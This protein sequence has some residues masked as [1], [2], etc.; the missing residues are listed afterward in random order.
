ML[1]LGQ[2]VAGEPH[3]PFRNAALKALFGLATVK[4]VELQLGVGEA[5]ALLAT[6]TPH[7]VIYN[8][9]IC[10]YIA[11]RTGDG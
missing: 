4:D 11:L 9:D 2:L 10:M 7:K 1:S 5:L 6:A 8:I 3:A